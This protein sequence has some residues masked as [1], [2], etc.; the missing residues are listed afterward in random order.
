MS[1]AIEYE[2]KGD[3]AVLR[4]NNPP[5]NALGHAVRSGLIAGLERAESEAKAVLIVGAGR[6][7]FAGADIKEFGK[8]LLEPG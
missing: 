2:L 3:I 5:V 1:N 8:P 4:A 7:Y 6:T